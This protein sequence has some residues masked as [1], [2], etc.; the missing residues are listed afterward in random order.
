MTYNVAL[1]DQKTPSVKDSVATRGHL[2]SLLLGAMNT[3]AHN[4]IQMDGW[5]CCTKLS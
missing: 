3:F 4:P 1:P 2:G 5:Q